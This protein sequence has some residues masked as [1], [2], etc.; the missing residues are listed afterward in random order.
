MGFSTNF[1]AIKEE[2]DGNK[3]SFS[4]CYQNPHFCQVLSCKV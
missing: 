3:R 4:A 1:V 2:V